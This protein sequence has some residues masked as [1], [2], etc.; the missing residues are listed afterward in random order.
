MSCSN[1]LSPFRYRSP[2]IVMALWSF[3]PMRLCIRLVPSSLD[4]VA[5]FRQK[6]HGGRSSPECSADAKEHPS[7]MILPQHDLYTCIFEY[8]GSSKKQMGH[9]S[10]L[11]GGLNK[12]SS[13]NSATRLLHSFLCC[14]RWACWQAMEQYFTSLHAVHVFSPSPPFPQA[15]H[16]AVVLLVDAAMVFN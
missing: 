5:G 10:R 2:I 16:D 13:C 1:P 9:S 7:Q 11:G 14:G 8:N 3:N 12:A 15:A 4:R 6:G